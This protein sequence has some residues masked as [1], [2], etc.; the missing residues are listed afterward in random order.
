MGG[1][2]ALARI[3]ARLELLY[4]NPDASMYKLI[5]LDYSM[6]DMNGP[7]V[8]QRIREILT[9]EQQPYIACCTA[10]D[11]INFR[12]MA[13]EAGMDQFLNKPV[14]MDKIKELLKEVE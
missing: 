5:L 3:D 11:D 2:I 4:E 12:K 10:Y 8:C 1:R 9:P 7:E 14:E 13:M 6:P